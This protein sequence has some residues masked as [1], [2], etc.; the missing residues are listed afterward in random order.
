MPIYLL[1]DNL[2]DKRN[3]GLTKHFFEFLIPIIAFIQ[4][5]IENL[6]GFGQFPF[7]DKNHLEQEF[8]AEGID[9]T[10]AVLADENDHRQE[11][12]SNRGYHRQENKRIGIE[13][14]KSRNHPDV[15]QNPDKG[16]DQ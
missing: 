9:I 5:I 14:R 1:L 10:L 12:G 7:G 6:Q 15:Y 8:I 11:N 16:D 3:I 4:A 2:L 13:N